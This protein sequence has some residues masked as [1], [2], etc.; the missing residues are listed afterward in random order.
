MRK[1]ATVLMVSGLVLAFGSVPQSAKAD[2]VE[3]YWFSGAGVSDPSLGGSIL[4]AEAPTGDPQFIYDRGTGIMR[5]VTNGH[6]LTEIVVPGPGQDTPITDPVTPRDPSW[7]PSMRLPAGVIVNG[8]F[9]IVVW[10]GTYFAGK[11]QAF[12]K[13]SEGADGEFV[14]AQWDVGL[15][16]SDFGPVEWGS[17]P[18]SG[19]TGING[20]G[21]VQVEGVPEPATM[22]LLTIGG[23]MLARKRRRQRC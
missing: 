15:S 1:L 3:G 13:L 11:F 12:D 22:A 23:L 10:D 21:V 4:P 18:V 20:L 17:L 8:R 6:F 14:L 16:A 5:T 19:G 7:L 2:D 9:E